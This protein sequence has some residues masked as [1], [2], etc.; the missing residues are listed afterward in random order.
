MG[1]I[2]FLDNFPET[3]DQPLSYSALAQLSGMSRPEATELSLTWEEWTGSRRLELIERLAGLQEDHND[4]EFEVVF[5]EGLKLDDPHCRALSL[6]GLAESHDRTLVAT[7]SSVLRE[8]P[9]PRVR[10][11]AARASVGL[12]GLA[13][14]GRLPERDGNQLCATLHEVLDDENETNGVKLGALETIGLF[15][16]GHVERHITRLGA[17]V[18]PATLRSVLIAAAR[19]SDPHWLPLTTRHIDHFDAGV[20]YEAIAAL[21]EIG[22]EEHAHR[23]AP[24]LDDQDL[25]VQE[26]A[27]SALGLLGGPDAV[28]LLNQAKGSPEPSIAAAAGETLIMLAAEDGV[29]DITPP[30]FDLAG[31][32]FG[33]VVRPGGDSPDDE[34]SPADREGWAHLLENG[35]HT[36]DEPRLN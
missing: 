20:R 35:A 36:P 3:E 25:A 33:P 14:Q 30:D 34:Y 18:D 10:E 16:R 15:G 27:V 21:G 5:K 17:D 7:F 19:T 29:L 26:A 1:L 4:L 8:D 11:E 32:V 9:V 28:G 23:L 22:G 2:E 6:A 31:G 12:A 24:A 13:A